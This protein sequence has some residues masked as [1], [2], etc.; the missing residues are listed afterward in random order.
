MIAASITPTAVISAPLAHHDRVVTS[1]F[2]APTTKWAPVLMMNDATTAGM[3]TVKKNG[4]IGTNP[5]IAVD[6]VADSVD[7]QGLG[8]V[9]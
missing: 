4:M 1:D 9:S 2:A 6:S 7:R 8:N 3:P 5:P